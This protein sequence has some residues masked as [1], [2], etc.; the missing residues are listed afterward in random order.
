M[1]VS[2]GFCWDITWFVVNG[3]GLWRGDTSVIIIIIILTY[4]ILLFI[5]YL[6]CIGFV[7]LNVYVG[8]SQ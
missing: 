8:T 7:C 2:Y 1:V 6:V 4:Y 5:C 3:A